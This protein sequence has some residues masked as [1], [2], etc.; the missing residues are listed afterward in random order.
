MNPIVKGALAAGV[1]RLGLEV[2]RDPE[3]AR[4]FRDALLGPE[5]KR[6][7]RRHGF[8]PPGE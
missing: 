6:L 2:P 3:L 5:G 4:S 1:E 7:P 8:F